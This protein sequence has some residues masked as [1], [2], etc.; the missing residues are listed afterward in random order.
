M[1]DRIKAL[2]RLR[3]TD[4]KI[5]KPRT[6]SSGEYV[7]RVPQL[8]ISNVTLAHAGFH[9]G[10]FVLLTST[11]PGVLVLI[12]DPDQRQTRAHIRRVRR[13]MGRRAQMP[14]PDRIGP[15]RR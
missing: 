2:A 15:Q 12:R 9:P 3:V 6:A 10:D 1:T 11:R 5:K 13:A 8:R 14:G 4:R 7:Y